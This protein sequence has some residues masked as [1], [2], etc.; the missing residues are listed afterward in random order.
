MSSA[1]NKSR[2]HEGDHKDKTGLKLK[3]ESM[4]KKLDDFQH[5]TNLKDLGDMCFTQT[6]GS[7]L[8]NHN[9]SSP[10]KAFQW[11]FQKHIRKCDEEATYYMCTPNPDAPLCKDDKVSEND[12][13]NNAVYV[14]KDQKFGEKEIPLIHK[15]I[16]GETLTCTPQPTSNLSCFKDILKNGVVM[17]VSKDPKKC[18]KAGKFLKK[19]TGKQCFAKDVSI[20]QIYAPVTV[21]E[22]WGGRLHSGTSPIYACVCDGSN[23]KVCPKGEIVTG[24]SQY[25]LDEAN[26]LQ[27]AANYS[28]LKQLSLEDVAAA[29]TRHHHSS[30]HSTALR[31]TRKQST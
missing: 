24:L 28:E 9:K 4:S 8:I 19:A 25:S 12:V 5:V 27:C 10:N 7:V 18:P 14:F 20:E 3:L 1:L 6:K 22:A 15:Q 31:L 21:E 17:E 30:S 29:G 26:K 13:L 11:R 23:Q 2:K 16:N